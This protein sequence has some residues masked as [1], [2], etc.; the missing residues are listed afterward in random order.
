MSQVKSFERVSDEDGE[1]AQVICDPG[2]GNAVTA[3]HYQAAGTDAPPLAGD[4]AALE[5]AQGEEVAVGYA[6]PA[7][8]GTAAPG[9][10][11]TYSRD[12]D[13]AVV[14]QLHLMADGKI[15]LT[16]PGVRIG[17]AGA[18]EALTLGTTQKDEL[19]RVLNVLAAI[20]NV[21]TGA[22]INEPGSGSPSALQAAIDSALT[23]LSLPADLDSTISTKHRID[24]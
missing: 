10:H 15:V 8:A 7:N 5:G 14:A 11:R 4:Y 9:E 6:D 23:G 16:S 17:A 12:G 19:T 18:A 1:G 24:E 2:D 20:Y 22:P 21:I 13:G 3:E